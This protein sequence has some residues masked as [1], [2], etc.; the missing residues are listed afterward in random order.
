M[1]WLCTAFR[2]TTRHYLATLFPSSIPTTETGTSASTVVDSR[3][4][5]T[6]G[7]L[8]DTKERVTQ[9]APFELADCT[10]WVCGHTVELATHHAPCTS[11]HDTQGARLSSRI[12]PLEFAGTQLQV[13][14][15]R[16][17]ARHRR[18]RNSSI[19]HAPCISHHAPCTS[20]HAPCISHHA[21]CIPHHAPYTMC[22]A[23]R[24]VRPPCTTG[25]HRA[26]GTVCHAPCTCAIHHHWHATCV[27]HCMPCTTTMHH[28]E[29]PVHHICV[30]AP[31]PGGMTGH[32]VTNMYTWCLLPQV[33]HL[34][35]FPLSESESG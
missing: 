7:R 26:L 25:M 30:D 33:T 10:A 22:L 4:A 32:E 20:H 2:V 29:P 18:A 1:Y 8:I 6:E 23:P 11:H 28:P 17:H 19:R 9:G 35:S 31:H 13:L 16:V 21:P 3:K 24:T 15:C 12:A 5:R 14:A 27:M 34:C